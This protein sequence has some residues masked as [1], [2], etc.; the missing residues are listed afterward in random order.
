[1]SEALLEQ[2]APL[3]VRVSGR[4]LRT[5]LRYGQRARDRAEAFAPGSIRPLY[6][7]TLNL[8]HDRSIEV[9]G[10]ADR[11]LRL[12][13]RR[14]RL[15]LEADLSG[16]PLELVQ[17]RTL[18]G[19]SPEFYARRERRAA[20]LRII[21]AADVPAFGLV[22]LGS[23]NTP[24]ELRA[25]KGAWLQAMIP[26]GHRCSCE[27]AGRHCD[28]V[29]FAPGSLD[30]LA[31][32]AGPDVLAVAGSFEK[33]LGSKQ[34]GTLLLERTAGGVALGLTEPNTPSAAAVRAAAAV[35]PIHARPIVNLDAS[36]STIEG[37]TRHYE[38]A[39][40]SAI[41]VKTAPPE[42]R[43]GWDPAEVTGAD[44]EARRRRLWL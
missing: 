28:S 39:V 11:S 40:V 42:R 8:Q 19:V 29:V 38:R 3:E 36:E 2:A 1:M 22:D 10:S 43:E 9:A 30:D 16:A 21:T 17:R 13:E 14:D 23:Y 26:E 33:V 5:E 7:V 25:L 24:L 20:G 6:P 4:T 44:P 32:P 34:A 35:A 15:L 18:R 41:L 27:C 12:G 37:A 31:D